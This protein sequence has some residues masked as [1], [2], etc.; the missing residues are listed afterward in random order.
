VLSG[1]FSAVRTASLPEH[2]PPPIIPQALFSKNLA[3][4]AFLFRIEPSAKR[5]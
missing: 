5:P 3:F 4:Q 1:N 2:H